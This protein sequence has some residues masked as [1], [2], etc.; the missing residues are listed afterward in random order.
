MLYDDS[1]MRAEPVEH[2]HRQSRAEDAL[3][4]V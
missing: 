4:V 2:L 3:S 1:V